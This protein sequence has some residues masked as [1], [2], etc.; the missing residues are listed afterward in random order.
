MGTMM[1][2]FLDLVKNN[3]KCPFIKDFTKI[4]NSVIESIIYQ[5]TDCGI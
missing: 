4:L 5:L 2:K 3:L 1:Y